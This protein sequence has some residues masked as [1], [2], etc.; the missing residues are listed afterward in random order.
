MQYFT[1]QWRHNGRG[2]VSITSLTI[3]YFNVYSDA[4][5]RSPSS[6]PLAFVRG[7]HRWPVNSPHKWLVTRKM[8]QRDDVIINLFNFT[9]RGVM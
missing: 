6:V 9:V 3:I 1:L 4:D 2:G 7:I 5:Q 8:F